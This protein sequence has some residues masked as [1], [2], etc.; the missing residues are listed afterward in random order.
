M[1]AKG[2]E[3]AAA[4]GTASSSSLPAAQEAS[5]ASQ[6]SALEINEGEKWE[7]VFPAFV[8]RFASLRDREERLAEIA[9]DLRLMEEERRKAGVPPTFIELAAFVLLRES[10]DAA[11][12]G[13]PTAL[14]PPV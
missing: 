13:L 10:A 3:G 9:S 12:Q 8:T 11:L 2:S 6:Y 14:A 1:A 7:Q 4:G 5:L